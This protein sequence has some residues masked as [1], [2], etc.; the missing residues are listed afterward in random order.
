MGSSLFPAEQ[1]A[2]FDLLDSW[3]KRRPPRSVV[4]LSGDMHFAMKSQLMR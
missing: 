2:Y 4:V 1:G 3:R